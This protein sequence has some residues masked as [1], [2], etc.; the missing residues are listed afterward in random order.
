MYWAT[1]SSHPCASWTATSLIPPAELRANGD[2][3]SDG[4]VKLRWLPILGATGYG[5]RYIEE[6]CNSDDGVCDTHGSWQTP[7]AANLTITDQ[8][9]G[10]DAV[11]Q[12]SLG[13]LAAE[14]LYRI[15]VRS[16]VVSDSAWSEDEIEL[17]FPTESRLGDRTVATAPFHGYQPENAQG[18]HEFR[19]VTCTGTIST[20][21]ETPG[22]NAVAIARDIEDAIEK[23]ESTV[24]WDSGGNNIVTAKSYRPA[25]GENCTH[26]LKPVPFFNFIDEIP[27]GNDGFEV[28]FV[29]DE[30]IEAACDP[31]DQ[32]EKPIPGCWVSTSWLFPGI[33][34][35]T[36]GAILINE[37]LGA[38]PLEHS[39]SR[40]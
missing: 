36:E 13:G 8:T 22:R 23:W 5:V 14:T 1:P 28:K 34:Q 29:S 39:N 18:S 27:S 3:D 4:N 33:D 6:R 11:K 31:T 16:T 25:G 17:V 15:Q 19:Y 21:L 10:G 40:G 2:L 12:A 20:D 32:R 9:I 35:I 7:K 30:R 24:V 26:P 38:R 37:S